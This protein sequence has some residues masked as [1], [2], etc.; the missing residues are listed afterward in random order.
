MEGREGQFNRMTGLILYI[1]IISLDN[2]I[3]VGLL[4]ACKAVGSDNLTLKPVF[5][6]DPWFVKNAK[7]GIN[8]YSCRPIRP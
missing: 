3:C 4:E 6:L 2:M 8:R 7:V 5:L 1:Y